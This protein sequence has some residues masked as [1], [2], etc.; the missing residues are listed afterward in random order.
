MDDGFDSLL[1][2]GYDKEPDVSARDGIGRA[3]PHAGLL[4]PLGEIARG[5]LFRRIDGEFADGRD[6]AAARRDRKR[7]LL[8]RIV[9]NAHGVFAR[10]F[11]AD[12]AAEPLPHVEELLGNEG[13][14]Q[15]GGNVTQHRVWRDKL[16][17]HRVCDGARGRVRG[18]AEG[19]REHGDA[20]FPPGG[21]GHYG[22][23]PAGG[24]DLRVFDQGQVEEIERGEFGQR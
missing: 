12:D 1:I 19:A 2:K 23:L 18:D 15:R 6:R 21:L 8:Q 24:H 11:P 14:V 20:S 22:P 5:A 4:I 3:G 7:A 17:V 9:E 10:P 16:L 13:G